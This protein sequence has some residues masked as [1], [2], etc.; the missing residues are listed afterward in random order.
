MRVFILIPT[1]NEAENIERLIDE[2]FRLHIDVDLQ[3][4]VID[5][6]SP[7]GTGDLVEKL[8]KTRPALFCIH[9]TWKRGLGSAIREGC[10]YAVGEEADG[11]IT[12]D[13]DFSHH[14]KYVLSLIEASRH[15]DLV[16]GSRYI[17]GGSETGWSWQR[18]LLSRGANVLARTLLRLDI[19]DATAGF[20]YYSRHVFSRVPIQSLQSDGYSFQVEMVFACHRAGLTISE[21]PICFE[22]RRLGASKISRREVWN[23]AGTILRLFLK[24][25]K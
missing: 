17:A 6:A 5:D 8:R 14:P 1:Y 18:K 22:N 12:M 23:G 7:D 24:R 10:A 13:A 21:V 16:I 2:I 15:A 9:R 3:I 19:H 4:V 11:I 25:F 20:R